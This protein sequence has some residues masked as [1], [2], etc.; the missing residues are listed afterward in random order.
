MYASSIDQ[1]MHAPFLNYAC[2]YSDNIMRV[3]NLDHIMHTYDLVLIRH[4]LSLDL[5]MHVPIPGLT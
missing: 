1:I 2:L 4:V 5:I 3:P